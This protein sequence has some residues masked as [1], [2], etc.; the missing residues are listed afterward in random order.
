MVKEIKGKRRENKWEISERDTEHE[1]HLT[2]GNERGVVEGE[3]GGVDGV[4]G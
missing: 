4:T 2:L 1:R 3:V